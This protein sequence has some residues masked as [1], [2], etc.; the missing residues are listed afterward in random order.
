MRVFVVPT[1]HPTATRPLWCNWILPHIALLRENGVEAYV[2]QVGLDGEPV[3]EETAPWTQPIRFL[4]DHHLYVPVPVPARPYQRTSLFYGAYLRRYAERMREVYRLAVRK[5]GRPD[6]LHAHVSLPGGYLA[7]QLGQEFGI[8]VIVQ[9]HYSGF[10]SDARFP[11]RVGCFVREMGARIQGFYAV[12]PGQAARI[13]RTGLVSVTGVLPN[14]ID[15]DL[16]TLAP[17]EQNDSSGSFDIVTAGNMNLPKGADLLFEALHRLPAEIDW[18]LT[19]FGD[20]PHRKTFARWLDDPWFSSRL[21]S[22]GKVPQPELA[23]AYSQSDLYVVSSRIE[24]ANV[25]M[26]QAM[27]C[28]VPVVTTSC[29]APET[30]IDDSVGISV[31]PNDPQALAEGILEFVRSPRRFDPQ[32]L[33]RF[34]VERY[35]KRVVAEQVIEVYRRTLRNGGSWVRNVENGSRLP[36]KA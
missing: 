2:L 30:L 7:A 17:R 21:S 31:K 5:W 26:L 13:E 36:E 35:S 20:I 6:I 4:N 27:A 12:S 22:L 19:I 23:R 16:F 33:R 18:R 24:T 28:G 32:L 34:V 15:T 11:W 3:R 8:P 10:E 29:G 14:P 1:W 9:E 25:S